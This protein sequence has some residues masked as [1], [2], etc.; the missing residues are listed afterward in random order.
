MT[1][2][3]H[4]PGH[5]L[6]DEK[7]WVEK[8]DDYWANLPDFDSNGKPYI[9]ANAAPNVISDI[10]PETRHMANG[11]N[12]DSK[13]EFRKATKA[14]G[15]VEVGNDSSFLNP[16][17]RKNIELDRGQRREHLRQSIYELRN[18]IKRG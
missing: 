18:G 6:A 15:C 4:H 10:M 1:R 5:P 2:Y 12:Y 3:I 8:N 16:K 9:T 17:P 14:A 7:G 11:K 13:S